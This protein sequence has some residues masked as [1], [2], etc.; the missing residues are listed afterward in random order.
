MPMPSS[1]F[2]RS[3]PNAQV[4]MVCA[5]VA[6]QRLDTYV[7]VLESQVNHALL[8]ERTPQRERESS[9]DTRPVSL[10]NRYTLVLMCAPVGRKT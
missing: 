9:D 4:Y 7:G 6:I 8:S 1:L 3:F 10:T 2:Q 5:T